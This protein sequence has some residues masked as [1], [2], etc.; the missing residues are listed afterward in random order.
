MLMARM[1][2]RRDPFVVSIIISA[3]VPTRIGQ[4]FGMEQWAMAH[5]KGE[6]KMFSAARAREY[7]QNPRA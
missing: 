2:M 6:R 1:R 7:T 3:N 5:K 4:T